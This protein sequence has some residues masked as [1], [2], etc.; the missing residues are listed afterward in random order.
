MGGNYITWFREEGAKERSLLYKLENAGILRLHS[1]RNKNM[2]TIYQWKLTEKG[3][4]IVDEN[5]TLQEIWGEGLKIDVVKFYNEI[6]KIIGE[7]EKGHVQG[8]E[9]KGK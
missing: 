3:Q 1:E 5:K 9:K 4:K 2:L 8:E 6:M 7:E